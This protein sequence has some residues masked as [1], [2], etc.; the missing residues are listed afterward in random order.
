MAINPGVRLDAKTWT[1]AGYKGGSE[2]GVLSL[3]WYLVRHDGKAF[4]LSLVLNDPHRAI[5]ESSA[6]AVAEAAI[7]LLAKAG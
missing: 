2:P 4:V 7:A 6:A 1:Y 5:D 3:T